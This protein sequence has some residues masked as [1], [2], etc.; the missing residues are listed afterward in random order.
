MVAMGLLHRQAHCQ[1]P[2]TYL[3]V[4]QKIHAELIERLKY[5]TCEP[6]RILVMSDDPG[7]LY[8]QVKSLFPSAYVVQAGYSKTDLRRLKGRWMRKPSR[9]LIDNTKLAFKAHTFDLVLVSSVWRW[10]DKRFS[11]MASELARV[12]RAKGVLLT[13]VHDQGAKFASLP[14]MHDLGDS[15]LKA[16]FVDPVM[17]V[18][19]Y[20]QQE[21]IFGHAWGKQR[22]QHGKDGAV[23]INIDQL[24]DK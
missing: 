14:D 5:F 18:E 24:L 21:V 16:S 4:E 17:D 12:L 6:E 7:I 13:A 2:D 20:Q 8:P 22:Q 23:R 15:L 3:A 11:V 10:A 1:R 19:R 9:V